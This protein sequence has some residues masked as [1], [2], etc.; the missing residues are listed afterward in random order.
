MAR[1]KF[2]MKLSKRRG[3]RLRDKIWIPFSPQELERLETLMENHA[4]EAE[5]YLTQGEFR[6]LKQKFAEARDEWERRRSNLNV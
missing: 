2:R 4:L 5:D 1:N 6:E 3:C